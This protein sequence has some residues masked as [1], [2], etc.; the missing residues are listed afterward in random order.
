MTNK[1]NDELGMLVQKQLFRHKPEEGIYGDC[2]R[3]AL[4]ALFDMDAREVPHFNEGNPSSEEF[5]RRDAAWL[6]AQGYVK[7]NMVFPA[8]ELDDVLQTM[9]SLNPGIYYLLAG[10]SRTGV[11]HSV[12]CLDDQIICDPSLTDSGI[13]GPCADGYYW[14]TVL[15]PLRFTEHQHS[16]R[17]GP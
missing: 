3:T 6:K 12:V 4:A 14:V 7:Y 16:Q 1:A 9:K 10:T 8:A 11:D 15:V 2:H 5:N 13:I 17:S